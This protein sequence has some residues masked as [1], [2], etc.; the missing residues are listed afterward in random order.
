MRPELYINVLPYNNTT[1]SYTTYGLH[2]VKPLYSFFKRSL[3][4][5]ISLVFIILLCPIF[6]I[7]SVLIKCTSKGNVIFKQERIGLHGNVFTIYKFRTMAADTPEVSTSNFKNSCMYITPLGRILRKT[8]LD[9]LPQ[10]I[11]VL[12][13]DMS[14]V[15]PRPLIKSES[16]IH[17]ERMCKGVYD[18]RP[19]ITG[20]AQINGR[21]CIDDQQKIYFD[22]QYFMNRSIFLDAYIIFKTVFSVCKS[23]GYCEG[24]AKKK[25]TNKLWIYY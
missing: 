17:R 7:I 21:D 19:G 15:G 12:L 18:I 8:S 14:I 2:K 13:G 6:F 16:N 1:V 25:K 22:V 24:H 3:D 5:V 10:L 4:I 23:E 20:W 9:E 11:N